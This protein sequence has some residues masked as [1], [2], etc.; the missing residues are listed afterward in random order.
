MAEETSKSN[1]NHNQS[2]VGLSNCIASEWEGNHCILRRRRAQSGN[3]HRTSRCTMEVQRCTA[4]PWPL[5]RQENGSYQ[6][7]LGGLWSL[8]RVRWYVFRRTRVPPR[9]QSEWALKY[10]ET[11][12]ESCCWRIRDSL[13]RRWL[14]VAW[15]KRQCQIGNSCMVDR[16]R[17]RKDLQRHQGDGTTVKRR[18]KNQK[19]RKQ[20][21][22]LNGTWHDP[23]EGEHHWEATSQS[24]QPMQIRNRNWVIY[25]F[26]EVGLKLQS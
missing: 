19:I 18:Q 6:G 17:R 21:H 8:Q 5:H 12:S 15:S 23:T 9:K 25:R 7:R 2:V 10:E 20:V 26:Y 4:D 13:P 11:N 24:T 16:I 1:L 3:I 22:W 14:L